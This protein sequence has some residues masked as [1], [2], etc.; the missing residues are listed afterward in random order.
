MRCQAKS[1]P[2]TVCMA[3]ACTGM[4][5][6]SDT[7]PLCGSGCLT[8]PENVAVYVGQSCTQEGGVCLSW[9]EPSM[10]WDGV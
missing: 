5:T 7:Q 4:A 6:V 1:E 2:S 3:A 10:S 8:G 9:S